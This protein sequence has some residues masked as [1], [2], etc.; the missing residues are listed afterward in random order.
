MLI[1]NLSKSFE[2]STSRA[3]G[4]MTWKLDN[5]SILKARVAAPFEFI[6]RV[7][8]AVSFVC[9]PSQCANNYRS[10]LVVFD[11]LTLFLMRSGSLNVV[12]ILDGSVDAHCCASF[13]ASRLPRYPAEIGRH[14]LDGGMIG[15]RR[16]FWDR[17]AARTLMMSCAV[18][19][20]DECDFSSA[21][22]EHQSIVPR[23]WFAY[24]SFCTRNKVVMEM[25]GA[26]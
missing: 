10:L 14:E 13:L 2:N 19:F 24:R 5:D 1:E 9:R 3:G 11:F 18:Q 21:R 23:E 15:E 12:L 8:E 22:V 4:E 26:D 6:Y 25:E 16:G 17:P 7:P 20:S